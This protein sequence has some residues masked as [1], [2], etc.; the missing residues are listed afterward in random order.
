[1]CTAILMAAWT[2]VDNGYYR[3]GHEHC[4]VLKF[5]N[6]KL[7]ESSYLRFLHVK[8]L[9]GTINQEKA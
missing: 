1:M 2:A 6:H 9:A 4:D 3:A 7:V 5:H 8:V